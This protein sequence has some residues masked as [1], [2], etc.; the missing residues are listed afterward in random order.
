MTTDFL[1]LES[2]FTGATPE[3][4]DD[5]RRCLSGIRF[6]F[7]GSLFGTVRPQQSHWLV[8]WVGKQLNQ[9]CRSYRLAA[10]NLSKRCDERLRR[11]AWSSLLPSLRHLAGTKLT[12]GL[13]TRSFET[14]FYRTHL[15]TM[16]PTL[17]IYR[18]LS[19]A[20]G[21]LTRDD[22]IAN[23]CKPGKCT[24]QYRA[25][26]FLGKFSNPIAHQ[27]RMNHYEENNVDQRI[28]VRRKSD[29]DR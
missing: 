4:S 3:L 6:G 14:N 22:R 11:E 25:W 1:N 18:S 20:T 16:L 19:P 29:C 15:Q 10:A 13:L 27:E 21:C 24:K 12:K 26:Q 8:R 9:K 28:P 17:G 5:S 7:N 23:Q 2:V